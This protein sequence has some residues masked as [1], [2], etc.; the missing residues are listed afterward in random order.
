MERE[1]ELG[2][3]GCDS[4]CDGRFALPE[5]LEFRTLPDM[6]RILC[7]ASLPVFSVFLHCLYFLSLQHT[8]LESA[9][10]NQLSSQKA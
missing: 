9:S 1:T 2:D 10:L 8:L 7:E 4:V 5:I 6:A 3:W